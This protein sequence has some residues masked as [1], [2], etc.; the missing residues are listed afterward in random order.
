MRQGK[1]AWSSCCIFPTCEL[2]GCEL[3]V[4]LFWFCNERS[5]LCQ[6]K[7]STGQE[8]QETLGQEK[9]LIVY[10]TV[11]RWLVGKAHEHF[12]GAAR[13]GYHE[14]RDYLKKRSH[15][16]KKSVRIPGKSKLFFHNHNFKNIHGPKKDLGIL[17]HIFG[18]A[19]SNTDFRWGL[20]LHLPMPFQ[21]SQC[22]GPWPGMTVIGD[23]PWDT[24]PFALILEKFF[25]G[26]EGS[27][28]ILLYI[29]TELVQRTRRG[30]ECWIYSIDVKCHLCVQ[31]GLERGH[32]SPA[33][34][35]V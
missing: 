25:S 4:F 3:E 19:L 32:R 17:W 1:C 9:Q 2:L 16:S 18:G 33:C 20:L 10:M 6:G 22:F 27:G 21:G 14:V 5:R 34:P 28:G 8:D 13:Q 23:S 7:H 35:A 24:S 31:T 26:G 12:V 11:R 30:R 15:F 29:N